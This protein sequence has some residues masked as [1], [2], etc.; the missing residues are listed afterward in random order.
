MHHFAR[1]GSRVGSITD[2]TLL[3]SAGI[4]FQHAFLLNLGSVFVLGCIPL[5]GGAICAFSRRRFIGTN[6]AEM[7]RQAIFVETAMTMSVVLSYVFLSGIISR[8]FRALPCFELQSLS[9]DI[10]I[11]KLA[12]DPDNDCTVS[13]YTIL[14]YIFIGLYGALLFYLNLWTLVQNRGQL[15]EARVR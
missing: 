5:I 2:F 3:C 11:E 10:T 15:D 7:P 4:G 8:L 1:G 13:V 9:S 12:Y 14:A 6:D